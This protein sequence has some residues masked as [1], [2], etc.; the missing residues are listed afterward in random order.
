MKFEVTST[1]GIT[2][3]EKEIDTLQELLDFV[4]ESGNNVIIAEPWPDEELWRLEIY[5]GWR[6]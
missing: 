5:D 4:K 1:T 3:R 6:E 2:A